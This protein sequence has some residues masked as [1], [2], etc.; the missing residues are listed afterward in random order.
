MKLD[1]GIMSLPTF[2]GF[3]A[4]VFLAMIMVTYGAIKFN[5][6][7]TKRNNDVFT[8]TSD[9]FFDHN[10][11]FDHHS[12]LDLA[13]GFTAYD[14]EREVILDKSIGELAFIAYVWGEDE[15]GVGYVRRDKIP[16]RMCTRE[17]L[18]LDPGNRRFFQLKD[19]SVNQLEMYHKKMLCV[20]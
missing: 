4:T 12:G 7:I 16:S 9:H 13:I 14:S 10:F 8:T 6:L 3:C 2:S 5:S 18:G 11:V 15:N 20:D 17:E 19:F 1:K